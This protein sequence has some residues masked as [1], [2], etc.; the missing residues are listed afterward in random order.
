MHELDSIMTFLNP[1]CPADW[2]ATKIAVISAVRIFVIPTKPEYPVTQLSLSALLHPPTLDCPLP[3]I[4]AFVLNLI[5]A[6]REG[7][8]NPVSHSKEH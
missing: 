3:V 5:N 8:L 2:R 4:L 1:F 7:V 6:L